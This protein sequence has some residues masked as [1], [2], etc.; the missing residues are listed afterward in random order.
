MQIDATPF[1]PAIPTF[2]PTVFVPRTARSRATDIAS[3]GRRTMAYL[4][5]G[6]SVAAATAAV[7]IFASAVAGVTDR[8]LLPAVIV[9]A[10]TFLAA[11]AYFPMLEARRGQTIGKQLMRI[12]VVAADG[13][14]ATARQCWLRHAAWLVDGIGFAGLFLEARSPRR[15]RL[16]DILAD[17]IVINA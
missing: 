9:S 2:R 3:L 12:K 15:Q 1:Q 10:V 8:G 17:T 7:W 11:F 13:A 5:D 4:I 6:L 16:G 14:P